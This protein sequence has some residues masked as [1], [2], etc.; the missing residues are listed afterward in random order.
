M[1]K[2]RAQS[3]ECS[4][5]VTLGIARV[6]KVSSENLQLRSTLEV[7]QF[8]F[9][10]KEALATVE[11]C[12]LCGWR[13]L[14]HFYIVS[15]TPSSCDA[16]GCELQRVVHRSLLRPET[17]WKNTRRKARLCVYFN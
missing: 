13:F 10:M 11:I 2:N 3:A 4:L 7:I 5:D 9:R 16:V 12:V 1:L 8:E 6:E 15:E 14:N 17:D